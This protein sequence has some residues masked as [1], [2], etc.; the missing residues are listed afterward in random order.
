MTVG[1]VQTKIRLLFVK[2]PYCLIGTKHRRQ[3]RNC[4]AC[5]VRRTLLDCRLV[6]LIQ[7]VDMPDKPGG[8]EGQADRMHRYQTDGPAGQRL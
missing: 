5:R 8:G 7:A 3:C 6:G 4:T 2:T 1:S